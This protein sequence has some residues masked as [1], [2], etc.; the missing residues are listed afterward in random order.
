MLRINKRADYAVRIILA[1]SKR[2]FGTRIAAKYI[3]E[4]MAI[5]QAFLRRIVADLAR[6][7]LIRTYLGPHGGL[8]LSR[9]AE[10]ISMYD[11]IEAIEG[12]IS[13]TTCLTDDDDCPLEPECSVRGSW[14][15]LQSLMIAE[16]KNTS[17]AELAA[18]QVIP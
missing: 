6:S 15:R 4:E 14:E 5:P 10:E 18:E 13:L 17:M 7:G 12:S 2:P 3:Q 11:I 16:M 8:Q 1:L 9:P